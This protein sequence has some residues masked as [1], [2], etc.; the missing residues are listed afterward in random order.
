[1]NYTVIDKT[2][3][4]RIRHF[5]YFKTLKNPHLGVTINVDVTDLLEYCK[6]HNYSF[7]LSFIHFVALA[8][9]DIEEFHYRILNNEI[10]R[11]EEC[12]TSHIEDM[13]DGTYCYCTLHH[14]MPFNE[15]IE[16]ATKTRNICKENGS[17]DEDEDVL[18]QYFISCL[19]WISYT[20]LIQPTADEN[21]SNPRVTWGKY[22]INTNGKY[23]MPVS[24]LVHHGLVDGIHIGKFYELL[25]SKISNAVH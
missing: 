1:M 11:F 2:K 13:K 5:E 23:M 22:E 25:N 7:Y 10:V 3:Y 20:S 12:S 15:Y 8:L 21:D 9:D 14:H 24:I 17:V 19:P 16:Y 18:S 4:P 6:K